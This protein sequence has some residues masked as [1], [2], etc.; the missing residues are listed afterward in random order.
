L[1]G[2]PLSHRGGHAVFA[3]HP[4]GDILLTGGGDHAARLWRLPGPA[5]GAPQRLECWLQVLTGT[6]LDEHGAVQ[7]LD[8]AAWQEQR[9]RL[10]T[11]GGPP[12]R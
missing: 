6:K 7:L 2:P 11:L 1:L 4:D 12:A 8:A 9:R 10:E 5:Q 3:L